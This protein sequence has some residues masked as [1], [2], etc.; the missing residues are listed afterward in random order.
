MM[1]ETEIAKEIEPVI[2]SLR[3]DLRDCILLLAD[4]DFRASDIVDKLLDGDSLDDILD[5]L[6]SAFIEV[7][8][9]SDDMQSF[10]LLHG[11]PSYDQV[12]YR[13]CGCS[14][15]F[16]GYDAHE[17]SLDLADSLLDHY[18]QTI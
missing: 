18:A 13:Y 12:H 11:D 17:V 1:T 4:D 2:E 16:W 3:D 5:G 9:G 6:D 10:R 8:L 14:T 15:L 7:R